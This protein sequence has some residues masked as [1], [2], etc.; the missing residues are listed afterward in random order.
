MLTEIE[1]RP[2]YVQPNRSSTASALARSSLKWHTARAKSYHPISDLS[3]PKL[4]SS[5]KRELKIMRTRMKRWKT[6]RGPQ[7]R[8]PHA[9]GT[10]GPRSLSLKGWTMLKRSGK[11]NLKWNAVG[12]ESAGFNEAVEQ[13]E[14][15][16]KKTA[17]T[18]PAVAAAQEGPSEAMLLSNKKPNLYEHIKIFAGRRTI[19]LRCCGRGQLSS[20][21]YHILS[22]T[23]YA[24]PGP[25]STKRTN[26]L[27]RFSGATTLACDKSKGST[28]PKSCGI[29]DP[30]S[31]SQKIK[32]NAKMCTW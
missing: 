8:A 29:G 32:K 12:V 17:R 16:S 30:I 20:R 1:R 25:P 3:M 15:A 22:V 11:R 10:S 18:E 14:R 4:R 28:I 2:T 27:G 6:T 13:V 7:R 19:G 21:A 26:T 23:S 31:D 24:D 9:F 5:R